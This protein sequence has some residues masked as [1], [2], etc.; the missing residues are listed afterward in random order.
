MTH[1]NTEAIKNDT[2]FIGTNIPTIESR[3]DAIRHG[4]DLAKHG[5]FMTW[6]SPI[7]F[8]TFAKWLR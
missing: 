3:I 2:S 1:S 4:V 8:P 5:M 6:I 7:N